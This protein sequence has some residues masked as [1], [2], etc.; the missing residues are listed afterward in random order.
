MHRFSESQVRLQTGECITIRAV[1]PDDAPAVR[2]FL[3]GLSEESR[4]LRYHSP[5]P[6]V[7]WWMVEAVTASDHDQREAIL[8]LRDER[9]VGVAEWGREPEAHGR[10]HVAIAVDEGFRRRGLAQT[11]TRR[12]AAIARQHGLEEFVATVMTVNRPVFGLLDRVAPVRSRRF[13]G[14]AVEVVIPLRPDPA[15]AATA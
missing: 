2:T 13:D 6:V 11:L 1:R 9:V 12:L 4:R 15:V 10:A 14:D 7:R 3:E 8:A 5:V